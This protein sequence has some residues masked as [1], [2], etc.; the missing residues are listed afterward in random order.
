MLFFL[1]FF[2]FFFNLY[3][4]DSLCGRCATINDEKIFIDS[5]S[6]AKGEGLR[7][8][9]Q[10]DKTALILLDK[11]QQ[12]LRTN[13]GR[14]SLGLAGVGLIAYGVLSG[15]KKSGAFTK[16][17]M[18]GTGI[19]LLIL[20]YFLGKTADY[21]NEKIL[22]NA[23]R[24][25]NKSSLPKIYFAPAIESDQNFEMGIGIEKKF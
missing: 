3:A 10:K 14:T 17:T 7:P 20:N 23:I 19:G 1:F 12:G 15:S 16:E 11:Y 5:S 6:Y 25:Y 2:F 18:M 21:Q 22:H 13:W 4:N 8:Y 9:L 24:E